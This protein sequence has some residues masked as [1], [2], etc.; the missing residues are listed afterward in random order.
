V[1][2]LRE[3]RFALVA[4]LAAALILDV[5]INPRSLFSRLMSTKWLVWVGSISYGL[6]L[7]HWPIF[8]GM[9]Q[10]GFKGWTVVLAGLPVTLVVVSLSYYLLE[11]PM[12]RLKQRF[13]RDDLA[14]A[15]HG[16]ADPPL[17]ARAQPEPRHLEPRS[18][19]LRDVHGKTSYCRRTRVR[20]LTGE[21]VRHAHN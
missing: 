5:L 13:T 1:T 15:D 6:Y 21:L 8:Y 17:K 11:R 9:H 14:Q 20:L 3:L 7:W 19:W 16:Q 2:F 4:L 18:G 12:L 10:F